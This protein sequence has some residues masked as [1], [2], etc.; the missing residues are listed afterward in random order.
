VSLRLRSTV[1]L[2]GRGENDFVVIVNKICAHSLFHYHTTARYTPRMDVHRP[3]CPWLW[4]Q[5]R[6]RNELMV[7]GFGGGGGVFLSDK[8]AINDWNVQFQRKGQPVS[9]LSALNKAF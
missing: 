6:C 8:T 4:P 7:N 5:L 2:F 9:N 3:T 1:P